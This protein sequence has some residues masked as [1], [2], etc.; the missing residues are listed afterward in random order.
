MSNLDIA[1]PLRTALISVAEISGPLALWNNEPAVF[2][3]RP[4]PADA[5]FPMI[6]INPAAAITDQDYLDRQLPIVMRD[7]GIY[8]RQPDDVRIVD[9]ISYAIRDHF[10]RN[11]WA[12]TPDGFG[13]I[14]I[15]ARGPFPGP[16]DSATTIG[17]IVGLTIQ[18]RRN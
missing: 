12:I 16:T 17:R 1:A 6:V 8:G 18:L 3:R 2:T 14:Q 7:I 4:V 9:A 10:H 11:R 5:S 15:I 13:V